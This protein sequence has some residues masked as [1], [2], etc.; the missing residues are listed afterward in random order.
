MRSWLVALCLV[1][2]VQAHDYD[3]AASEVGPEDVT[4]TYPDVPPID[5]GP[6]STITELRG[7]LDGV[8]LS[9]LVVTS[10]QA[11][12]C[13]PYSDTPL[14]EVEQRFARP[15]DPSTDFLSLTWVVTTAEPTAIGS[16]SLRWGPDRAE[17]RGLPVIGAVRLESDRAQ[18]RAAVEFDGGI[19]ASIDGWVCPL[20]VCI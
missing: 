17:R 6:C 5:A 12:T 7:A 2:C 13:I 19:S 8:D 1:G 14:F 20:W 3:A 4:A 10:E 18:L 15:D 9:T 11:T 16:V